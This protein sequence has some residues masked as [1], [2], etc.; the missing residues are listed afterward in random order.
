I[1][2]IIVNRIDLV[3]SVEVPLPPLSEQER[4]VAILDKAIAA[5]VTATANTEK[6][7]ANARELGSVT[8]LELLTRGSDDWSSTTIGEQVLLQRGF[9]IT[10]KQQVSGPVPVVSSGGIKSYHAKAMVAEPGVVIGR[11]G[12]IG[13]VH[14]VTEDY[15]PHD[16]TL[17]VKDFKGNNPRFVYHFF[18]AMDLAG[19]D[20][21]AANPALNRNMI[22]PLPVSW[23]STEL[24]EEIVRR[25]DNV[26]SLS[27]SLGRIYFDKQLVLTELKQ[28]ILY[29]AF[30]GELTTDAKAVDRTLSEAGL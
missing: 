18:K 20:S 30:T 6:N 23:P 11:K 26:E 25:T 3:R 15:W 10:K 19:L 9:D 5:I 22:H 29:K 17:W 28:S 13:Q 7:L 12:S 4:I 21:G 27:Q 24:Q 1:K 8:F 16:T 14:Y 2:S